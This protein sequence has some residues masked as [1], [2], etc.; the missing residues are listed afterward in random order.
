MRLSKHPSRGIK[1]ILQDLNQVLRTP[2][3]FE[4]EGKTAYFYTTKNGTSPASAPGTTTTSLSSVPPSTPSSTAQT[5]S[6][7]PSST[8][9]S[10]PKSSFSMISSPLPMT[11]FIRPPTLSTLS[12]SPPDLFSTFLVFICFD[13]DFLVIV[14]FNTPLFS[15]ALFY[16]LYQPAFFFAVFCFFR[17]IFGC[18]AISLAFAFLCGGEYNRNP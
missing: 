2:P 4:K 6:A 17:F 18:Y 12:T 16:L 1:A 13:L 14:F 15:V 3:S 11:L 5:S 8:R 10:D 9:S 7:S